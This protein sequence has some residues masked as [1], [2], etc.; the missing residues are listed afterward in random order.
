MK[1]GTGNISELTIKQL[2]KE[3]NI[4]ESKKGIISNEEI[5]LLVKLRNELSFKF[6]FNY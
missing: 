6:N 4:I 3:I 5:Q 2:E 1:N